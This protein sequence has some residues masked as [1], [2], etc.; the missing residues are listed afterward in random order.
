MNKKFFFKI[1]VYH[2]VCLLQIHYQLPSLHVP[3]APNYLDDFLC[4]VP[5]SRKTLLPPELL[6]YW[7][8]RKSAD[9]E[10]CIFVEKK[11]SILK[12]SKTTEA[13]ICGTLLANKFRFLI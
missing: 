10:V 7:L 4:A 13:T 6:G 9:E 2:M 8:I 3:I 1:L 5:I 12:N 11:H